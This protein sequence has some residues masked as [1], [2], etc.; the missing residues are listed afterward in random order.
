MI[1]VN[2]AGGDEQPPFKAEM[3]TIAQLKAS[4]L[5]RVS[6]LKLF[7][8]ANAMVGLYRQG[9][10]TGGASLQTLCATPKSTKPGLL[11]L[12]CARAHRRDKRDNIAAVLPRY[13]R[14][15]RACKPSKMKSR[16]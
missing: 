2:A 14:H 15:E 6:A 9:A 5:V 16:Y 4:M 3:L 10:V 13:N 11:S 1:S 12:R 7:C 8:A